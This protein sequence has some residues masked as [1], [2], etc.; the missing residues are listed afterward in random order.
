MT[1]EGLK[2][3][4]DVDRSQSITPQTGRR[5]DRTIIAVL[6][7]AVLFLL[8]Q[9]F[10]GIET[11]TTLEPSA[12]P[13]A[14]TDTEPPAPDR[15][16]KT[17]AVL[18]FR[19]MSAAQDQAYFGEGIAEELLN[20][21]VKL[22]GVKVASRTSAF[23]LA[24]EDLDIP[25]MAARLGVDHILEGS[26]R[27][28]GRQVRVT[29]QLIEVSE[30][31]HLWSDTYDG[32]L[33]DIFRIQDEI[34][35]EI[36]EAMK[37]Q[38]GGMALRPASEELT[39]NAEAY[40][41]YLQGRHLW[42]QRNNASLREAIALFEEAVE[43]D[44]QFDRAWSNLAIAHFNL[45]DYDHDAVF[46]DSI[47]QGLAAAERALAINPQSTEALIIQANYL[48]MKCQ[49]AESARRYEAAIALAPND[50]TAHHW[51][52]LLLMFSGRTMAALEQ[53]RIA[54]ELDPL[55]S[56]VISVESRLQNL[57]N[58]HRKSAELALR[59]ASLGLHG[60]SPVPAG[61]AYL[62]DGDFERGRQRVLEGEP[63]ATP[64]VIESRRLFVAALGE[65]SRL[66]AFEANAGTANPKEPFASIDV[67]GMLAMLGS[68]YLFTFYA[69]VECP[70]VSADVWLDEFRLL[71]GTPEFFELMS[72][73]GIVEFWREFGWPDECASLDQ[74][75]A[76]CPE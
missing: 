12:E 48:E 3:E 19:D 56:A 49:F 73:A 10:S 69:E 63:D 59:A 13:V 37:V 51:Y 28:S 44:P 40:Q 68:E 50:P 22:E 62:L 29:A 27:T 34:T 53:I 57:V 65:R 55:I 24:D 21:L 9:Q 25:A 54:H 46:W 64:Q 4:R 38:L 60:G 72:R 74:S 52:A 1:P 36:S 58:D 70:H 30:D 7:L 15:G 16:V 18:P 39:D 17:I 6:A 8:Y 2:R 23:S 45:P 47:G 71:R 61:L 11:G 43:I 41:R 35:A 31:V 76:E 33:D 67:A 20:A 14:T 26:I 32:T 42:R 5:L 75:L 66:P